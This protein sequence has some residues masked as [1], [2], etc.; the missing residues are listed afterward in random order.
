MDPNRHFEH[1]KLLTGSPS[2]ADWIVKSGSSS[3]VL[4]ARLVFSWLA[5]RS[6]IGL[7]AS[8]RDI[9]RHTGLHF[10]TVAEALGS[11]SGLIQH[12]GN[13][14][15]ALEPPSGMF[16]QIT[17]TKPQHWTDHFAYLMLYLPAKGAKVTYPQTTRK[18]G[19]NHAL[20]WS[21][22]FRKAKDGVVRRFT[23]AGAAALFGL[24]E[25]T[26]KAVLDDLLWLRLIT[27][28]DLGRS[29]DITMLPLTDDHLALFQSKPETQGKP[30]EPVEKKPRS[31]AAPYKFRGDHWDACRRLCDGLMPQ[32][33]AEDAIAKATHLGNTPDD[34][35]TLFRRA[36]ERHNNN[37]LAGKV[38]KGNFGKYLV[39]CFDNRMK[40]LAER[41]RAAERLQRLEAHY[42]SPEY[43]QKQADDEK[44]A[45][46]DPLHRYFNSDD[47]AIL[48]RVQFDPNPRENIRALDQMR[49]QVHLRITLF[50]SNKNLLLQQK[51]DASGILR[52]KIL[53]HALANVNHYYQQPV[54]ASGEE[55]QSQID[56]ACQKFAPETVGVDN[57]LS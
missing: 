15:E 44:S 43:K 35:E 4:Q 10:E 34:F 49:K 31:A 37:I 12:Q 41:E 26:V 46:A 27:R 20:I 45:L 52:H 56:A 23:V 1:F 40:K 9:I 38:A 42:S 47:K 51:V 33:R 13:Q 17:P 11:L 7:G 25:K 32:K 54:L 36:K 2:F 28:E 48:E 19:R 24:D 6:R 22:L 50:L 16:V 57:R 39:A 5:H 55:F 29:S 30:V 14:W 3:T 8:A 53:S 21:F 18:F